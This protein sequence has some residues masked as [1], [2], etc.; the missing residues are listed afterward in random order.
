[1]FKGS[2][3]FLTCCGAS[4]NCD[5]VPSLTWVEQKFKMRGGK[6]NFDPNK[7]ENM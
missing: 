7:G 3:L 1:M 6:F 5:K 4:A 2:Y